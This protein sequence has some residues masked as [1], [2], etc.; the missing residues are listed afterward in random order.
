MEEL[1]SLQ[2]R[3]EVDKGQRVI[4][5]QAAAR[6]DGHKCYESH[7]VKEVIEEITAFYKEGS[8]KEVDMNRYWEDLDTRH[9]ASMWKKPW[10]ILA[11]C[12]KFKL[13]SWS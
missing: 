8:I 4:W 13:K 7:G 3:I 1:A 6:S 11:S 2:F 9:F 5:V 12:D 10:R